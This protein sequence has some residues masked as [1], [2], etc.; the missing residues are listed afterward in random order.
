MEYKQ[1]HAQDGSVHLWGTRWDLDGT[2]GTSTSVVVTHTYARATSPFVSPQ[3]TDL[4]YRLVIG[5]RHRPGSE[6]P[7]DLEVV[8]DVQEALHP[9]LLNDPCWLNAGRYASHDA[10]LAALEGK[11]RIAGWRE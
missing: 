7:W 4:R 10:A 9:D 2:I 8:Y 3:I 1:Q 5:F 11:A 6:N